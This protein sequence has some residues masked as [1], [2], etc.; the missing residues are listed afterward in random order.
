MDIERSFVKEKKSIVRNVQGPCKR[1]GTYREINCFYCK[2]D[3]IT[4]DI[5]KFNE[6]KKELDDIKLWKKNVMPT[7]Q[8]V[9]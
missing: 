5:E 9:Y 6:Y 2:E 3:F 7:K 8:K 4:E 1:E